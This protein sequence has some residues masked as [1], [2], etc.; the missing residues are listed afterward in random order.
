MPEMLSLKVFMSVY[1]FSYIILYF[2]L[3]L[4]TAVYALLITCL[5]SYKFCYNVI[6]LLP[7]FDIF[8]SREAIFYEIYFFFNSSPFVIFV[9]FYVAYF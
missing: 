8:Y 4:K 1:S 6:I 5:D 9:I 2:C 7:V 3:S